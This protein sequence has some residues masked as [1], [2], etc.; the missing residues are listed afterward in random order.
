MTLL[1][2]WNS[3]LIPPFVFLVFLLFL[4]LLQHDTGRE[5]DAYFFERQET[6]IN[7]CFAFDLFLRA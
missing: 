2:L 4:M 6:L 7:Q 1:F 3:S 5:V